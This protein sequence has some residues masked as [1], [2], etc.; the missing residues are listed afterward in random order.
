MLFENSGQLYTRSC[1][2]HKCQTG[3]KYWTSL[4]L[5][6]TVTFLQQNSQR[7]CVKRNNTKCT[8]LYLLEYKTTTQ[9]TTSAKGKCIFPNLRWH[10]PTPRPQEVPRKNLLL[11]ISHTE[12]TKHVRL[13]STF[14]NQCHCLHLHS[15]CLHLPHTPNISILS[16][17]HC[18]HLHT[19]C[20]PL[21][22]HH[23]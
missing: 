2:I 5:R 18:L 19:Q 20:L 14:P 16:Q 7:T 15:Q 6:N 11:V 3:Y 21:P 8:V 17:C 22:H 13:L 10:P 12:Y 9:K 4:F 1:I 23:S